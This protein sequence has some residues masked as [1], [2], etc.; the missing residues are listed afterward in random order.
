MNG[1]HADLF[2]LAMTTHETHFTL[3]WKNQVLLWK[4][5]IRNRCCEKGH[6][7][8]QCKSEVK[9]REAVGVPTKAEQL[10]FAYIHFLREYL[11][12]EIQVPDCLFWEFKQPLDDFVFRRFF[13]GNDFLQHLLLLEIHT[14]DIDNLMD[15]C[16][17]ELN[18]LGGFLTENG[19]SSEVELWLFREVS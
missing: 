2:I 4:N 10:Q 6:T 8:E 12:N 15:V 11:K 3:L 13:V 5:Q 7:N 1:I 19:S 18:G 17:N 9:P 16:R 14:R